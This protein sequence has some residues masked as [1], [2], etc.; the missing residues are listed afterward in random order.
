MDVKEHKMG[1][2]KNQLEANITNE[3]DD[4]MSES[5]ASQDDIDYQVYLYT[6]K[7]NTKCIEQTSKLMNH[8]DRK[9][10]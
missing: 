2:L 1:C 6:N 8:L 9:Q 7:F 3:S 4:A 10:E 5:Q